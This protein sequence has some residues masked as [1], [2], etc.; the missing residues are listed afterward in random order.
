M[1]MGELPLLYINYLTRR[2][3]HLRLP[4]GEEDNTEEP[5]RPELE[6]GYLETV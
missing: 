5:S 4:D 1:E 6:I 3:L 2:D